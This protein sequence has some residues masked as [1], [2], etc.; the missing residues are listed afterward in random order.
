MAKALLMAMA[1]CSRRSRRIYRVAN[2]FLAFYLN[3]PRGSA[4]RSCPRRRRSSCPAAEDEPFRHF[5]FRTALRDELEDL[6]LARN[7]LGR[8]YP[9]RSGGEGRDP[10]GE[11]DDI[12]E[13]VDVR[14][15]STS[16]STAPEIRHASR[17]ADSGDT[18]GLPTG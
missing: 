4:R 16:S 17:R 11:R 7:Q 8:W 3:V 9:V 13:Q 1:G 15:P 10:L 2:N 6:G 5:G 14:S 18:N 12:A